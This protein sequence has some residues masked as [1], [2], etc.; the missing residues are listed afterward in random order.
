MLKGRADSKHQ[1]ESSAHS[2]VLGHMNAVLATILMF[3]VNFVAWYLIKKLCL[4]EKRMRP[5]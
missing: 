3:G 5:N 4:K 1:P 2:P